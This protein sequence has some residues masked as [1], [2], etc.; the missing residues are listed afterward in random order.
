MRGAL[1][2]TA[3][4]PSGFKVEWHRVHG[5]YQGARALYVILP[6]RSPNRTRYVPGHLEEHAGIIFDAFA[7][8]ILEPQQVNDRLRHLRRPDSPSTLPRN[9]PFR[10]SRI[11]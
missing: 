3:V 2:R 8:D 7:Q 6:R 5:T 10:G 4:S 11:K 9:F 1:I